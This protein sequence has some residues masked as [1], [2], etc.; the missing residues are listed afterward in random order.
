[1]NKMPFVSSVCAELL[2]GIE[3]YAT[4]VGKEDLVRAIKVECKPF[5][6]RA[7]K[8][9]APSAY[10]NHMSVCVKSKTG[11]IQDRFRECAKE[12]RSKHG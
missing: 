3:E 7:R 2:S 10:N 5:E 12:W 6:K 1:V 9:R 4:R 8:K 11:R